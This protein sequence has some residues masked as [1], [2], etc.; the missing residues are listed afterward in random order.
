M[1]SASRANTIAVEFVSH[2]G[3]TYT[4]SANLSTN[5][6]IL[7][8]DGFTI[9]D[10]ALPGTITAPTGWATSTTLS[11]SPV[12]TVGAL[13]VLLSPGGDDPTVANVHFVRSGGPIPLGSGPIPLGTFSVTTTAL[14][15]GS[16]IAVSKDSGSDS[17]TAFGPVPVAQLVPL[18]S[19]ANM[20]LVLLGGLGGLGALRR[21]K[22]SKTV[23]A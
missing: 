5:G 8:G 1:A 20:G 23:E 13:G 6:A 21:L 2:I 9:F 15:T 11:G 10:F 4:Y 22:N 16:D 19:T 17:P 7:N 18:P 12:P 3:S 14:F